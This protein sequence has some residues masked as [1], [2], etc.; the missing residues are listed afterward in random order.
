MTQ[1]IDLTTGSVKGHI[2]RMTPP[3]ILGMFSM[4]A[5][6]ITDTFFIAKLGT[7]PLAAMGFTFPLVMVLHALAFGLGMGISASISKAIGR[8][9]TDKVQV[10]TTY[11]LVLIFLIILVVAV[12]GQLFLDPLITLLGAG[13]ETLPLTRLYLRIWL[14]S[15]PL[16][17]LP[18]AGN[19]ALRATGDSLNPGIIMATAALIN[20]CLDPLLIFGFGPFPAMGI[21]GAALATAVSRILTLVWSLWILKVHKNLIIFRWPGKDSVLYAWKQVLHVALP[22]GATNL[23]IPVTMGIVTRMVAGYGAHAVAA[24]AA[25][26]RVEQF[27]FM[28]PMAMGSVLMPIIGQNWGAGQHRRAVTAWRLCIQYAALYSVLCFVLFLI[29]GHRVAGLFSAD[30]AVVQIIT[31][32]LWIITA[33]SVM[34]HSI[35]YTGFAFNA[36]GKPF[37][38][39]LVMIVRLVVL[40]VPLAGLGSYLYGIEGL[41]GGISLAYLLGGVLSIT[42]FI[43]Y[44]RHSHD[45]ERVPVTHDGTV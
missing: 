28:F 40:L 39:S 15:S 41:F 27:V 30:S 4:M 32:Y 13:E 8:G 21:A 43:Y 20:F 11:S 3:M 7:V 26:Q 12:L 19:N 35:A 18:M 34:V 9:D 1:M 17:V 42:W 33:G 44:T 37:H 2:L 29:A 45:M 6:N 10:L 5:F 23:L 36:I 24:T 25:G 22:A 16:G 38:A 31:R 14:A